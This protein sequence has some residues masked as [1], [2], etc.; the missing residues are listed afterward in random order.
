MKAP[1]ILKAH[2]RGVFMTAIDNVG[3]TMLWWE[4]FGDVAGNQILVC[5]LQL[6]MYQ[7]YDVTH[8]TAKE[9]EH[10]VDGQK[11]RLLVHRKGATRAYPP[12]HPS[13]P[14]RSDPLLCPC[15]RQAASGSVCFSIVPS[16]SVCFLFL[17]DK[18]KFLVQL[19]AHTHVD[20][21]SGN[22]VHASQAAICRVIGLAPPSF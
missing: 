6:G 21:S 13:L 10:Q 9:E 12:G 17:Q 5:Y 15:C 7:V 4:C 1:R 8:N 20:S 3:G 19:A 2:T 11:K 14:E 22:V 16:Y 18:P